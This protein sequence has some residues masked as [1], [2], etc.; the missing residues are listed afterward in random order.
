MKEVIVDFDEKGQPVISVKGVKG[1][2]CKDL[3][4]DLEKALGTVTKTELTPEYNQQETN[5]ATDRAYNRGR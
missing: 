2:A 1:K 4:R 5:R 3:T